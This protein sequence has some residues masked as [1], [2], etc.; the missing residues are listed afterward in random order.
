MWEN[1][2]FADYDSSKEKENDGDSQVDLESNKGMQ[3]LTATGCTQLRRTVAG[4][5]QLNNTSSI[6]RSLC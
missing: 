2:K 6:R 1:S 5:H 4:H 3:V